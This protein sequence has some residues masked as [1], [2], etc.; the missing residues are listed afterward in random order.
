MKPKPTNEDIQRLRMNGFKVEKHN[1]AS[2][3][4][5]WSQPTNI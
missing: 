3:R 4:I 5:D 2:Y 1:N